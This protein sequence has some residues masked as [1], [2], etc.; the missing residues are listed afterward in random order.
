[1]AAILSAACS[2]PE[3]PDTTR[4]IGVT[5]VPIIK[6]AADGA[7]DM[8]VATDAGTTQS[9]SPVGRASSTE[10]HTNL[11]GSTAAVPVAP[12]SDTQG[13]STSRGGPVDAT[14]VAHQEI[15]DAQAPANISDAASMPVSANIP[16]AATTQSAKPCPDDAANVCSKCGTTFAIAG[17]PCLGGICDGKGTCGPAP[18]CGDGIVNQASE[19]C[20]DGNH[21]DEDD[22][23]TNCKAAVCG[24][25]LVNRYGTD[26]DLK[27]EC[28]PKSPG[29]SAWNCSACKR[30]TMYLSCSSPA[31]CSDG[32]ACYVS[33]NKRCSKECNAGPSTG[34]GLLGPA[35]GCPTPPAPL[36]AFCNRAL[37]VC[38][39][40]NC[41][42]TADCPPGELCTQLTD[43]GNS[44]PY[45]SICANPAN[46]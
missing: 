34:L 16:D 36:S 31:D 39:V 13:M 29:A 6:H 33:W 45:A 19:Q 30:S 17:T 38:I 43:S 26:A 10:G 11:D 40:V 15:E 1:M 21:I 9:A 7:V 23:L 5:C 25:G 35:T 41:R 24:D 18:T 14:P 3:C 32:E 2:D 28:D 22:C 27:E 37:A 44:L 46:P 42:S 12:A 20:D 8:G 4:K